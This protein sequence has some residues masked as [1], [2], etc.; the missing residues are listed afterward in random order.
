MKTKLEGMVNWILCGGLLLYHELC[1]D[2][3]YGWRSAIQF[4]SS[5]N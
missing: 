3:I 1:V 4:M 2:Q 5:I